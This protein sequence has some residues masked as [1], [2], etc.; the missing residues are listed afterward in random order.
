MQL[1]ATDAKIDAAID[2][3]KRDGKAFQSLVHRVAF[4]ILKRGVDTK[5]FTKGAV[6]MTALVA[7][8]PGASR[9]NALIAWAE[10]FTPMRW[11]KEEKAF[12]YTN[13]KGFTVD[14]ADAKR[15]PF[16]DFVPEPEYT[17]IVDFDKL[18]E[19]LVKR[20]EKDVAEVGKKSKV[21]SAKLDALKALVA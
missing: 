19:G 4:S 14:L 7:A 13:M 12:Q 2:R 9:T 11:N 15:T 8:M 1:F 16:W 17:P 21:D 6:Q 3:V 18:I 10:A 5:D 20:A